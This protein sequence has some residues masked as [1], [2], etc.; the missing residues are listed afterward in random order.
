MAAASFQIGAAGSSGQVAWWHLR[1][2]LGSLVVE[3]G[4]EWRSGRGNAGHFFFSYSSWQTGLGPEEELGHA[5]SCL[6]R[7]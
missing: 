5:Q 1:F 4:A 2:R 3:S 6:P 7:L